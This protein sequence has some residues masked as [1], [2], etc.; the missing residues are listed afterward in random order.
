MTPG[1]KPMVCS[2]AGRL[3]IPIPTWFVKKIKAVCISA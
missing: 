1:I 2:I 3:R